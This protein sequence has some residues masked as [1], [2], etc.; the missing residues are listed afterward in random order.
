MLAVVAAALGLAAPAAATSGFTLVYAQRDAARAIADGAQGVPGVSGTWRQGPVFDDPR[1]PA[2][3]QVAKVSGAALAAQD[4]DGM[5]QTLRQSLAGSGR[6]AVEE[7]GSGVWGVEQLARLRQALQDLGPDAARVVVYVGP[8][9][10]GQVSRVDLRRS[11]GPRPTALL[12]ALRAAG[13]VEISLYHGGGVPFT[14]SEAAAAATRWLARWAPGDPS[15]LHLLLGPDR[16]VGP[17]EVWARARSTPAGRQLLANGPGVWGLA[18]RPEG[19][20]WLQGY[21]AFLADPTAPP[22]DGDAVVPAGGGLTLARTGRQV[23]VGLARAGRVVVRLEP[24]TGGRP[25]A[26]AK[27]VGPIAPSLLRLPR[28]VRPGR[29]RVV[30][31][32][33]GDGLRD[34]ARLAVTLGATARMLPRP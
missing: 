9:L 18:T 16:G 12:D 15:A 22:A 25:R 24:L 6:T 31:V 28:D 20:A 17:G 26:L 11:P 23:V 30:A 33:L 13:D 8:G 10:V 21:R 2:G 3:R 4:A 1:W 29:Y 14:R 5:A 27:L 19:V 7:L 34:E 32:A